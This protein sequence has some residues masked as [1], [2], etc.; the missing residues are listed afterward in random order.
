M[1]SYIK[2][3]LTIF[4]P[5]T[6]FSQENPDK[7]TPLALTKANGRVSVESQ[8]PVDTNLFELSYVYLNNDF[9]VAKEKKF[10]NHKY[11][12]LQNT[13]YGNEIAKIPKKKPIKVHLDSFFVD[14]VVKA[15]FENNNP[16]TYITIINGHLIYK[17]LGKILDYKIDNGKVIR[18]TVSD[19][20][21]DRTIYY[22]D[23][24]G[25]YSK[26]DRSWPFAVGYRKD[27]TI[28]GKDTMLYQ[29]YSYYIISWRNE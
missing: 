17:K 3:L 16:Q 20:K 22:Q 29:E 23:F 13:I 6:S 5:L 15:F 10:L 4:I 25:L 1:T 9:K 27:G 24:S 18:I 8:Y 2:I 7:L 21:S 19:K 26:T 12:I 14:T 28:R 11:R